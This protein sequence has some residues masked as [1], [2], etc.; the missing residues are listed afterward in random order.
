VDQAVTIASVQ[1]GAATYS[2][3]P[4]TY[5]GVTAGI[6]A[7]VYYC[8]LGNPGDFP[9]AVTD[10]IALIQRGTLTFSNKV[11][12][13][14]AAGARAAVIYNNASGNFFG[15]LGSSN[16]NWIPAVAV[17]QSDGL[18][19]QTNA[20]ATVV[21]KPDPTQIYQYLD[22]TSMATPHV[23]GAVAF[24]T[25][26]FPGENIAQRIQRVLTNADVISGLLGKVHNGR[27]LNL[28]RIVDTDANGLPDWWE[29]EYFGHL[30]GTDPNADPDH[31]GL[32]NLSEWVA[33]TNP[34]NAASGLTLT[35]IPATNA[36]VL[37]WPSVAGKT[38]WLESATNLHTG[39]DTIV[40]TNLAATAPTNTITDP[41]ILSGTDRFYRVGVQ[42]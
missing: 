36:V 18:A 41:V 25:M 12:N 2:A 3:N 7:T 26:N 31:D 35:V 9:A 17:S 38:Y 42:Q 6:T 37:A 27:R 4:L 30:T 21:N 20:S 5:S 15:T 24:A 33:G 19:M 34:T 10:N 1:Q 32:N 29:Q 11:I 39:F 22:G 16:I 40:A 8:G 28:Q 23:S 13:A 14:M